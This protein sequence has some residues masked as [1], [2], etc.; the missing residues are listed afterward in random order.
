MKFYYVAWITGSSDV[1]PAV[2][3]SDFEAPN[4][5]LNSRDP[6][7][8]LVEV[9][10]DRAEAEKEMEEMIRLEKLY[11][12]FDGDERYEVIEEEA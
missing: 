8:P 2:I 4:I 9:F 1:Y 12:G 6:C 11:A 3:D 10:L 7:L 5:A